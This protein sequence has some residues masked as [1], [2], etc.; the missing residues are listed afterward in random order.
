MELREW[1]NIQE[2]LLFVFGPVLTWWIVGLVVAC[3]MAA[4][5]IPV[6][7]VLRGI[8]RRWT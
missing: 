7:S 6:F 1:Q 2:A 8:V 3:V 5:L 4:I